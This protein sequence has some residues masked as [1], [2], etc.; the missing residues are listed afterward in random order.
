MQKTITSQYFI[1]ESSRDPEV[2]MSWPFR[3]K[4]TTDSL[5][6]DSLKISPSDQ[7]EEHIVAK[8]DETSRNFLVAWRPVEIHIIDVDIH[9]TYRV[10]LIKKESFWFEPLPDVVQKKQKQKK[11]KKNKYTCCYNLPEIEQESTHDMK[12]ENVSEEFAYS[13]EPFKHIVQKRNLSYG[14]E[15]GLR[16]SGTRTTIKYD[17]SVLYEPRVQRSIH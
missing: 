13:V 12:I 6:W 17:F 3:F 11:K 1:G 16:W 5:R 9:E 7:F 4:L 2:D 15:I 14:H 8:L 10:N